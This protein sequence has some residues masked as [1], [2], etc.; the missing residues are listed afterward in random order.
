M[1]NYLDRDQVL[2]LNQNQINNLNS[3]ITPKKYRSSHLKSTNQKKKNAQD[4]MGI[5]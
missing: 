4:Q 2:K 1:D 3:P 5:V